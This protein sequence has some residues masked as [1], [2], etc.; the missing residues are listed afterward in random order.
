M[1][2]DKL[3]AALLL[4]AA[5]GAAAQTA[6]LPRA[7]AAQMAVSLVPAL[8]DSATRACAAH[9]P[10]D[11]F[12][13]N[14]SRALAERLGADTAAVRSNAVAMILELTGQA[15]APGLD[16]GLMIPLFAD[17]L[18]EGLDAA[19]C[20]GAS[21]MLEALAPLP[22]ANVAQAVSAALGVALAQAGEDGPPICR[23]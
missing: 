15:P 20:R 10:A 13:G 12:L 8:I 21:E 7:Q 4:L 17:R 9:L 19:Q 22:T 3:A 5:Q 11:A 16:Q 18:T 14:G 23:E 1:T 6:C 2:I